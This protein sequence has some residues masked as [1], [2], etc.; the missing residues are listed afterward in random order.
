VPAGPGDVPAEVRRPVVDPDAAARAAEL[1]AADRARVGRLLAANDALALSP[2][3]DRQLREG[4]VDARLIIV[5]AGLA[6]VHRLEVAEFPA[7]PVEPADVPR[8]IVR[9]TAVDARAVTDPPVTT[10][11]RQWLQ[12][13]LP[14]YRPLAIERSGDSLLIRYAAPTPLGLLAH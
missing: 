5:L 10:L 1:D 12:A 2:V 9:I 4:S 3:A 7:V 8:R 13:Q 14:P 11:T 6:S